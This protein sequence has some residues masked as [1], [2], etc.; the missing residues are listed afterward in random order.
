[1]EKTRF[2]RQWRSALIVKVLGSTYPYPVLAKR[3]ESLWAKDGTLQSNSI[4]WGFYVVRFT[5]QLD[6]ERAAA[7]GP[8]MIGDH[9][10]TV[11][12]W[13][14][15]FDPK[16]V[17]VASTLVWAKFLALPIEYVKKKA[18]EKISSR[19][20]KPVRVDRATQNGERGKYARVFLEVDLTKPLL[21][22]I[23]GKKYYIEYEGLHNICTECGKYGHARVTCPSVMR[24]A[25]KET[26]AP[27]PT[28]PATETVDPTYGEWMMAKP[29]NG[30]NKRKPSEQKPLSKGTNTS[31]GAARRSAPPGSVESNE[32][33][34]QVLGDEEMSA[35]GGSGESQGVSQ[36]TM[37]ETLHQKGIKSAALKQ[38]SQGVPA[39][40]SVVQ[41]GH[42][43]SRD[44]PLCRT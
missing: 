28:N 41:D 44:H 18:A 35:N 32:S 27:E 2:R 14:K 4:S 10:L 33:R 13:R 6:Y 12:P 9:Y 29:R 37:L 43:E 11:R 31:E 21:S 8:W 20:G 36:D 40:P 1:M 15:G 7:G 42:P 34:F 25:S 3:L 19:M 30:K 16:D 23:V 26:V 24:E 5:H 38:A 22:K 17:E 39:I